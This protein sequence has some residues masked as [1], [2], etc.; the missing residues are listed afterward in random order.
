MTIQA[1]SDS[2]I[3]HQTSSEFKIDQT[4]SSSSALI[5]AYANAK[6]YLDK[7]RQTT[8][9]S[10]A[11]KSIKKTPL[12]ENREINR[13]SKTR[14]LHAQD[15]LLYQSIKLGRDEAPYDGILKEVCRVINR[16]HASASTDI[17]RITYHLKLILNEEKDR[18]KILGLL[19]YFLDTAPKV[20]FIEAKKLES[21]DF[22]DW[23]QSAFKKELSLLNDH[24]NRIRESHRKVGLQNANLAYQTKL[25]VKIAQLLLTKRRYINH[26]LINLI[27]DYFIKNKEMPLN[28]DFSLMNGLK[29]ILHS[30]SVR[31]K[32]RRIKKPH[33]KQKLAHDLIK[34]QLGLKTT[35]R[36]T[37]RDTII[38]ILTACLSRLRQGSVGSCFAT[39]LAII[40]HSSYLEHCLDDFINL[41]S[42]GK[43]SKTV[44]N[45][46]KSFP[47]LL[48]IGDQDL[49]ETMLHLSP[50]GKLFSEGHGEVYIWESPSIQATFQAIGVDDPIQTILNTLKTF[51]KNGNKDDYP[52][53]ISLQ[54]FI[55][56][57]CLEQIKMAGH[58]SSFLLAIFS[59]ASFAFQTQTRNGLLSVWGDCLAGM[60]EGKNGSMI[61][62]SVLNAICK[63]IKRHLNLL[64][65]SNNLSKNTAKA[66]SENLKEI[67]W[68]S[69]HLHYDPHIYNN[70]SIPPEGGFIIYDIKN[71][72]IPSKWK[73][74][75]TPELYQQFIVRLITNSKNHIKNTIKESHPD[76]DSDS[77]LNQLCLYIQTQVFLT[78]SM[79]T[80]YPKYNTHPSV[81]DIWEECPYTPWRTLSGNIAQSVHEVYLEMEE[82]FPTQQF[83]PKEPR[84]I[85]LNLIENIRMS[86]RDDESINAIPPHQRAPLLTSTHAFSLLPGHP[87]LIQAA[88]S[89]LTSSL[90]IDQ[91]IIQPGREVANSKVSEKTIQHTLAWI[92]K[93]LIKNE[94]SRRFNSAMRLMPKDLS[95]IEFRNWMITQLDAIIPTI[96]QDLE[97]MHLLETEICLSLNGDQQAKL[98]STAVHFAD[99][100]WNEGVNDINL[101]I[102]VHPCT[103]ELSILEIQDDNQLIRPIKDYTLLNGEWNYCLHTTETIN[104]K[105][106]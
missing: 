77:V 62:P 98:Q 71:Q 36:V 106:Y 12:N 54:M 61:K 87:S 29:M 21:V 99:T 57:I 14:N 27:I 32:L 41:I 90:W 13:S 46:M 44:G 49:S 7:D 78:K 20:V 31:S 94:N 35:S 28:H 18:S 47:F 30:S 51:P 45:T 76:I 10:L 82:S 8:R 25:S 63:P 37:T 2:F 83:N 9:L 101:C 11:S 68:H 85:L 24:I 74:I 66:I 50:D 64:L 52:I 70:E 39:H 22:I 67:L 55:K 80:Y 93:H 72:H 91:H 1:L 89:P 79:L 15:R 43:L 6:N 16:S 102:A 40:L 19:L 69:L 104:E 88:H 103:G 86:S 59:L 26:P 42:E 3:I 105:L 56:G 81:V 23:L 53:K 95:I 34:I 97:K 100:N 96:S 4:E 33:L 38:T 5:S 48:R 75:D 65:G 17:E 60:A 92:A 58:S 73:R 84:E